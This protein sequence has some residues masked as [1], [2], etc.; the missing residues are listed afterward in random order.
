MQESQEHYFEE[1]SLY[2]AISRFEDMVRANSTSYFDVYE[3]EVIID[4]YLD[5]HS[6]QMAEDALRI[7]LNQHPASLE[8]KYR[9]AQLYI[10]SGKPAKGMR[11]LRDIEFLESSNSDFYLL[12]GTALNLLGKKEE[13]SQA[14]S[15]AISVTTDNK[16]DVV[17]SIAQSFI[18]NRRYQS[19][20]KYLKLA[21]EINPKNID[22]IQE[23]ALVYERVDDLQSS[24]KYYQ[25]YLDIDP[26]NDNIWLNLGVLYTSTDKIEKS[27][28][29]FDFA[30]A[31][32][33][34]NIAALFSKANTCVNSGS[35]NEAIKTYH[36]L[37]ELEPDNVQVYTY[38]GECYEKM[39][40]YKRSTY[41]FKKALTIDENFADAWYGLGIAA[42]QQDLH[43]KSIDC[44]NKSL[45]IDPENPDYWFMIGEVYR[46]LEILEKAA[47]SFNRAVELDPND[48][49]AWIWRAELSFKNN[50]DLKGA[51]S[52]LKKAVEYNQDNSTIN[53][54]LATYYFHNNQSKLATQFFEQGLRIN[55]KEH[56]DFIENI[57]EKYSRHVVKELIIKHKK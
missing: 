28:D 12:K 1:D 30:L 11:L 10:N 14:F 22:V 17:Y 49:E 48:Y 31:I 21:Y 24:I 44:F 34:T 57:S 36:E 9:L 38:I 15:E 39:A 20:I 55:F 46:K 26:Y 4:Y 7:A 6:F 32:R 50:N 5:Q 13:A 23:L 56:H 29:A 3:F 52:I 25:R 27:I 37:L 53:Y 43:Q 18:N 54:Q 2:Q 51:I 35:Y 16:D 19:A 45:E 40:F 42:Y 33:P 41:F 47:E 8:L